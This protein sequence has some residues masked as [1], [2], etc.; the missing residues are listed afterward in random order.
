MSQRKC[1]TSTPP[2]YDG[3]P[4]ATRF[5]FTREQS[6]S[7]WSAWFAYRRLSVQTL[8]IVSERVRAR[9]LRVREDARVQVEVVVGLRLVDVAGA[10]A[11]DRLE[12]DQLE[13]HLGA[14]ACVDVSSS[15]AES[16]ARHPL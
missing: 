14:S 4:T 16:D 15:F 10:A 8:Q 2:E 11:R 5:S 1:T 7:F 6:A 3:A 9:L 13:A 12:L